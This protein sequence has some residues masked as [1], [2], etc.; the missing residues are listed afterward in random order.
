MKIKLKFGKLLIVF[1]LLSLIFM[2]L[3]GGGYTYWNAASPQKTCASCHEIGLSVNT[4]A[5]SPH[6]PLH[7]RE[8]HG[9]A[10][11]NG[12]HSL[13]EKSLMV[14]NH[15]NLQ[16]RENIKMD[17]LQMLEVQKN[18]KRC[19][20][21]EYAKWESGGHSATYT[22][23]FLD[24]VHNSTE[25]LNF[26]C[27]RCHGMYYKGTTYDLIE[28][29]NL[30]GPWKLKEQQ[31]ANL[32]TI[33]CL[34]CHKI[35]VQGKQHLRPNYSKPKNIFY[36]RPDSIFGFSF[37]DRHEKNHVAVNLVP[38]LNLSQK[39]EL[40]KVSDDPLMRGCIQCHAP[41]SWR[42]AGTGDDRTPRGV[43]EGL[44]CMAC[45]EP[46]SNSARNSCSKCHP[47]ISNCKKD[48]TKMNTSY[49]DPQSPNNIHWVSC[50]DC[51]P[52]KNIT[53]KNKR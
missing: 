41:N 6:A 7:C 47:A 38:K 11:S 15:F 21:S 24:S 40:I 23:I 35:H 45:H 42:E 31:M 25:Q 48:V 36:H 26:D 46:H 37:Y 44:S 29:L 30:K 27:L 19:H 16:K 34:A 13:K 9:T 49:V 43:H 39:G 8:C 10:F 28:P 51:H 5:N 22:D 3:F 50:N 14:V 33:P 17:E 18:C 12:L 1:L 52:V 2:V 20:A 53:L 4:L 32:P